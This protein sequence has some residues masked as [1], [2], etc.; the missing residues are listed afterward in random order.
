MIKGFIYKITNDINDKVYIGKTTLSSVEDRFQ[1]HLKDSQRVRFEKRPL[2]NAISKYGI[3]NFHIYLIEEVPLEQ[4]EDREKYWIKQ[5]DSYQNGYNATLGG[6]GKLQFDYEAIVKEYQKGSLIK[7]I[8]KKFNCSN[9][10]VARAISLAK[11]DTSLN[12]N[13]TLQKSIIMKKENKIINIFPSRKEA[14]L[15][16]Q[17][18]NYT[19]STN[20][21][22]II[23]A[24]GRVANGQRKSAYGFSW[25]N[26]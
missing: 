10:T 9:D 22:N 5:Y 7:E 21:D 16:L 23:A 26:I 8:A 24:I 18:N 15:W 20:L 4:L 1:E 17:K 25:E 12:Y 2:Y 6:D 19:K 11:M 14:S 13:K 3:E